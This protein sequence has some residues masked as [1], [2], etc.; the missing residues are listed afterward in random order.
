[1]AA[2]DKGR[3]VACGEF[4]GSTDTNAMRIGSEGEPSDA[5]VA[6]CQACTILRGDRFFA[7]EIGPAS[8]AMGWATIG[9][10]KRYISDIICLMAVPY[11]PSMRG[12]H[13]RPHDVFWPP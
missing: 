10:T 12:G 11:R 2:I 4:D 5:G 3:R 8:N 1:M 13:A 6:Q 9:E 7:F